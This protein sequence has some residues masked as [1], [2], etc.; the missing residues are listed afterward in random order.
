[1]VTGDESKIIAE[2]IAGDTMQYR[3]L[4]ERYQNPVYRVVLRI[5]GDT[6]DAKELTQDV[7]VKAFESLKQYNPDYKFFSWI[8]RIAIN[9]ALLHVK[10][11]SSFLQIDETIAQTKQVAGETID[12]ERRDYIMKQLIDR[13][14]EHYKSVIYLKYYTGLSYS[15]ISEVLG[16]PEKTIKSRLFDARKILKEKLTEMDFFSTIRMY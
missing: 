10:S 11:R 15:D 12:F 13:L 5:V 16:I 14:S 6:N 4:V 2:I 8:Y 1:M 9:N 3:V 7:F